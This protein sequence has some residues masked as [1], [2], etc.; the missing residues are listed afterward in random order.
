MI[1]YAFNVINRKGSR[2]TFSTICFGTFEGGY[3][4]DMIANAKATAKEMGGKLKDS[5]VQSWDGKTFYQ[6]VTMPTVD[7]ALTRKMLAAM[8]TDAAVL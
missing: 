5:K 3:I 1:T 6:V 2:A 7:S 8:F 4:G